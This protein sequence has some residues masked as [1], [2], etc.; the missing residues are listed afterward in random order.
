[1]TALQTLVTIAISG[2]QI[3]FEVVESTGPHDSRNV[4][5]QGNEGQLA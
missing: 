2:L 3:I 5:K 4:F 1:M